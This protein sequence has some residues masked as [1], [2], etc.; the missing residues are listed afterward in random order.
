[1]SDEDLADREIRARLEQ[2]AEIA[3]RRRL[4]QLRESQQAEIKIPLLPD[5]SDIREL[6]RAAE[7]TAFKVLYDMMIDEDAPAA[8]R[9][10]CADAIID[11]SRGKAAQEGT[12]KDDQKEKPTKIGD[13]K[14]KILKAI[15]NDKLD[16][17]LSEI[18]SAG[19]DSGE[20]EKAEQ[21][22]WSVVP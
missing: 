6:A 13:L 16:S 18:H 22:D 21:S 8:V 5:T 7:N 10:A 19:L 9:K 14:Q 20:D 12:K 1:M 2:E 11:R 4:K 17:I 3:E 15:P